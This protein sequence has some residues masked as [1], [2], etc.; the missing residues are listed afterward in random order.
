M[1]STKP[2]APGNSA[3]AFAGQSGSQCVHGDGSG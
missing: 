1:S 2:E 3:N